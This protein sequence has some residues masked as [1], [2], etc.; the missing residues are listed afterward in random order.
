[1]IPPKIHI[2]RYLFYSVRSCLDSAHQ[3]F[4]HN[5]VLMVALRTVHL[6]LPYSSALGDTW[7]LCRVESCHF[8][9]TY[10]LTSVLFLFTYMT[11]WTERRDPLHQYRSFPEWTFSQTSQNSGTVSV[12]I[13][14]GRGCCWKK[15]S[16]SLIHEQKHTHFLTLLCR[17]TNQYSC[18]DKFLEKVSNQPCSAIGYHCMTAASQIMFNQ[19]DLISRKK[20]TE[21]NSVQP[22]GDF[23]PFVTASQFRMSLG[24]KAYGSGQIAYNRLVYIL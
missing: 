24:G 3:T 12:W 2:Y 4:M 7:M 14:W 15:Q 18:L 19:P 8:R 1:M 17:K 13:F 22:A 10:S 20:R 21:G 5:P 23:S 16:K 11:Y 9:F 6:I